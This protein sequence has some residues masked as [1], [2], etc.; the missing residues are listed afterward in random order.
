MRRLLRSGAF[1]VALGYI[2]LGIAVLA[3]FAAPLWYSWRQN[4]EQVRTELLREDEQS[5]TDVFHSEGP[6]VLAAVI[7][8][9]VG[10][11]HVANSIILLADANL[12]PLAGNLEAW[13]PEAPDTPGVH[14]FMITQRQPP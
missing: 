8:A 9:R 11:Q 5:L 2:A 6:D 1:R 12:K 14:K 7:A 3:L 4:V 10:R 13:P